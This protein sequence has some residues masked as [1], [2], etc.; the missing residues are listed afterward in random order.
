MLSIHIM[1]VGGKDTMEKYVPILEAYSIPHVALVDYDYLC[2]DKK[3]IAK[4][5][6]KTQDFIILPRRL[7]E[8]L[9]CFDSNIAVISKFNT[10]DPCKTS[11]PDSITPAA[12]YHIV[13]KAMLNQKEKVKS[14]NLGKVVDTAI[15]KAGGDPDEFWAMHS[16]GT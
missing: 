11:N 9:S 16:T 14:S 1:N 15:S 13:L 3:K 4:S 7:E 2:D 6:N 12:A 5:R 8:E 10:N